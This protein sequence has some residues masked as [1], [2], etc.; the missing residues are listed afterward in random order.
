MGHSRGAAARPAHA[1][2]P[3]DGNAD[4][5]QVLP[6]LVAKVAAA[7]EGTLARLEQAGSVRGDGGGLF[8]HPSAVCFASRSRR[9]GS[10]ATGFTLCGDWGRQR[11]A[12]SAEFAWGFFQGHPEDPANEVQQEVRVRCLALASRWR[13]STNAPCSAEAAFS[14]LLRRVSVCGDDGHWYL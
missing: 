3:D 8:S 11:N 14:A 12:D 10:P 6:L 13:P 9:Q 1:G 2:V 7:G 5:N 4:K